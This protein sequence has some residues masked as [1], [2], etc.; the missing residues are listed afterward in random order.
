[1]KDNDKEYSDF[2]NV[3]SV[4]EDLVPEEF[5]EGA[6]GSSIDQDEPVSGKST[7]WKEGQSRQTA[8]R[9]TYKDVAAK[10]VVGDPP[11]SEYEESDEREKQ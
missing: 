6:F 4:R 10:D 11:F 8:F 7:P 9:H 5:P 1:M 3:K 2:S